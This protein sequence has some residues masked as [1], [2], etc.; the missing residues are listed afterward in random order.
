VAPAVPQD[1]APFAEHFYAAAYK[2]PNFRAPANVPFAVETP[3]L[4]PADA[5]V[6]PFPGMD[7]DTVI[8]WTVGI[9]DVTA[10]SRAALAAKAIKDVPVYAYMGAVVPITRIP[11]VDYPIIQAYRMPGCSTA[12][13]MLS[14]LRA[15]LALCGYPRVALAVD[16]T[17]RTTDGMGEWP[18]QDRI[19]F[20]LGV[21]DLCREIRPVAVFAWAWE[22]SVPQA[23]IASSPV[24]TEQWRRFVAAIPPEP[25][26]VPPAPP[27]VIE[28]PP[29]PPTDK[30]VSP[31]GKYELD[32]Q[33]DGN[34]V[35]YRRDGSV[36]WA[37]GVD[38][39]PLPPE[40]EPE[41]LPL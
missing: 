37:R 12:G 9:E 28:E 23:G 31:S 20:L 38:P 40:P 36:V 41:P 35:I 10:T 2:D 19:V 1:I 21:A 6:A 33:D 24:I 8:G 32:I 22:R 3:N 13:A 30:I 16:L 15:N 27:V 4:I 39:D 18:E 11:G 25:V 26:V 17:N 5:I 14:Q 29:M 34:L 7:V